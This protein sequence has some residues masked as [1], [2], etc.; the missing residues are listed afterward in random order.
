MGSGVEIVDIEKLAMI[1]S[2]KSFEQP[3]EPREG[4]ELQVYLPLPRLWE[5]RESTG[6]KCPTLLPQA[7]RSNDDNNDNNDNHDNHDNHDNYHWSDR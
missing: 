2:L 1:N 3:R 5:P 7:S 6:H 4:R